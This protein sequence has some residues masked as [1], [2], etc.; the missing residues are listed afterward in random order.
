MLH[1]KT[2]I[3]IFAL[4]EIKRNVYAGQYG[5]KNKME[6][7]FEEGERDPF[8]VEQ[9][10]NNNKMIVQLYDRRQPEQLQIKSSGRGRCKTSF[11]EEDIYLCIP[12]ILQLTINF[13]DFYF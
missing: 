2:I 7:N 5:D 9:F 3:D 11:L 12:V 6:V 1:P 4:T 13:W 10:G 8:F